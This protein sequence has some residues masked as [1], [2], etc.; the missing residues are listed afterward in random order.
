MVFKRR[1]NKSLVPEVWEWCKD[2]WYSNQ[3]RT[4]FALRRFENDV[5][6]YGI[7]TME[8][9]IM[10]LLEFENDVKIYGIQTKIFSSIHYLL[11]EN[12]VKIYGI[13]TDA[14]KTNVNKRLRMM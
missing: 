8:A 2:I 5:K 1:I 10:T 12:D 13:Q 6:I 3:A 14:W 11:F 9:L 7:Q 4:E